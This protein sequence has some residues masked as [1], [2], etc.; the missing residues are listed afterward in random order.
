MNE[1]WK[2]VN[3]IAGGHSKLR[4]AIHRKENLDAKNDDGWTPY[5]WA[6]RCGHQEV[7]EEL[8]NAGADTSGHFDAALLNAVFE[9]DLTNC[10]N[11]LRNGANP[12]RTL[13]GSTI[14]GCAAGHGFHQLVEVMI[15][16]GAKVESEILFEVCHWETADWKVDSQ[17][18]VGEYAKVVKAFLDAGADPNVKNADG[19]TPLQAIEGDGLNEIEDLLR[20]AQQGMAC[21]PQPLSNF[22]P[23]ALPTPGA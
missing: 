5:M 3:E 13:A 22:N 17:E 1:I 6:I 8:K 7:A 12:N 16:H 4:M 14:M 18:H 19:Q 9:N 21:D 10:I 2:A 15:K 20:N 11:A 23:N